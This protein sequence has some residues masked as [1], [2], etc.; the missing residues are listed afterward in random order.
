MVSLIIIHVMQVSITLIATGF[1]RQE[2]S[3]MRPLQGN[4]LTQGD[5]SLG[6]NRRPASFL[7]GGSVEIPE[8]LRKKGRSRYPRA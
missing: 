2:E 1:K 4:Q 7:E 6:T 8:F 3:D 5:A